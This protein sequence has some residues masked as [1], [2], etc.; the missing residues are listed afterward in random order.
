ML[1]TRV[2]YRTCLEANY[3]G[4]PRLVPPNYRMGLYELPDADNE[5]WDV[6]QMPDNWRAFPYPPATQKMGGDWLSKQKAT[7]LVLPCVA[8]P[9]G[10][11]QIALFNPLHAGVKNLVLKEVSEEIYSPRMF[12][13]R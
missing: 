9:F 6:S 7:L 5:T 10:L 13:S 2:W 11:D 4:S 12:S 8:T 3:M 1:R